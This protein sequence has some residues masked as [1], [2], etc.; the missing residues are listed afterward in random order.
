MID[1][2][3]SARSG[4]PVDLSGSQVVDPV[5]D[6][7]LNY[8]P[9]FVPG[10][11]LYVP[12]A[13]DG[14]NTANAPGGRAFNINAFTEALDANG[15]PV[16]G[17]VPRNLMRG[18]DAVQVDMGLARDFSLVERLKLQ[19][20]AEAFNA[21]NHPTMGAVDGTLG[22]GPGQFGFASGSLNNQGGA[23]SALY[24]NGGP[25]SLQLALKLMF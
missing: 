20:K 5:T 10:Q 23:E 14:V 22:D 13:T 8:E 2:R 18:F 9:N 6:A 15:N 12:T 3:I 7:E 16:N 11:P 24:A 17:N 19:F 21:F 25:R 1:S 4:F